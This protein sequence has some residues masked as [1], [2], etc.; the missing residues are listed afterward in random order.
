[1]Q[2]IGSTFVR[3][4][5]VAGCFIGGFLRQAVSRVLS[6]LVA[7]FGVFRVLFEPLIVA[8]VGLIYLLL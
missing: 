6:L 8:G 1:M 7:L 2:P 4:Q 5:R 3:V